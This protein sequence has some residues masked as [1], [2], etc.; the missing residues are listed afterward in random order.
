MIFTKDRLT[1]YEHQV[2]NEAKGMSRYY[3]ATAIKA[4]AELSDVD[5]FHD[6]SHVFSG[7][8]KPY[9]VDSVHIT[10]AGNEIVARRMLMDIVPIVQLWQK[11]A[12]GRTIDFQESSSRSLSTLAP[13]SH[14]SRANSKKAPAVPSVPA[15]RR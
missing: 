14:T 7:D 9:F 6:I 4:N 10:G 1:I 15:F 13:V 11:R 2:A 8:P 5:I 12:S 3:Q